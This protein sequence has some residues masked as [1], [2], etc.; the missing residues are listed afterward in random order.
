MVCKEG[1]TYKAAGLSP[2]LCD[3]PFVHFLAK[4]IGQDQYGL[5]ETDYF[6]GNGSQSAALYNQGELLWRAGPQKRGPIDTLIHKLDQSLNPNN[7]FTLLGL[8]SYR[9]FNDFFPDY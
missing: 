1:L 7:G 6:G 2:I 4:E 5:L 3:C 9:H 8:D